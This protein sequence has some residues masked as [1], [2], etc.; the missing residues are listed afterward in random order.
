M[1]LPGKRVLHSGFTPETEVVII[2][3]SA[4]YPSME[5]QMLECISPEFIIPDSKKVPD[6][7]LRRIGISILSHRDRRY[8]NVRRVRSYPLL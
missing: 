7:G 8:G 4:L 3:T 6:L 1:P 2:E 5:E